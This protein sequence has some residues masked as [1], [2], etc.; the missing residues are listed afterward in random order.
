MT[1]TSVYRKQ[2]LPSIN[3][4]MAPRSTNAAIDMSEVPWQAV[5]DFG[6]ALL[7]IGEAIRDGE[8]ADNLVQAH[9]E[10]D[11][12]VKKGKEDQLQ[13]QYNRA[14]NPSTT[15]QP[16]ASPTQ[17]QNLTEQRPLSLGHQLSSIGSYA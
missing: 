8:K 3:T 2:F 10:L 1:R 9:L 14:S 13:D 4:G 11:D 7:D 15:V 6:K 12:I 5:Q 16:S 17:Q